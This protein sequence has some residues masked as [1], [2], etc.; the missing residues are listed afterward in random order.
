MNEGMQNMFIYIITWILNIVI[1][2]AAM[3]TQIQ[4]KKIQTLTM[5][6]PTTLVE[7]SLV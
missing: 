5:K 4:V 6:L 7:I 1:A 2:V 3:M